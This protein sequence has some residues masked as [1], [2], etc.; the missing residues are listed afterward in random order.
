[1][2]TGYWLGVDLGGTKILAGLF[3]DDL[4]LLARSKQPTAA[5]TGPAGVFGNIV[6][7]VDAV[8]RE[9]NV[10]PAQIRGMGIG[11]PGQIEL[12]TTRVKFAPNLEWRDVDVRP[13]MPA[14]WRWPLVVENDVRMGTYGEFAYGAAKGARNVLGVFVGTGVGGGLILNGELF[15]GFNGN[16]GEIGH[17]VVHWRRGTH[18]EGIA[19]R[20]YMMKRAKDKLDD[21]PKR[22][23]K[24]WKGVDLSA[25]RSSQLAEYYQK[26]DPIAV[27]LVDDAA[28]ALGGA[29]GGLINFVSPEVIVLGGGVTGAL[30]DN[31][32]ERIW[33]IAQRYT[34]PGAAA[35][36]RCV[37]AQLG[38]DSG[39]VGCAAYAKSRTPVVAPTEVV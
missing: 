8:V 14:S 38:D 36:V 20:K 24:E 29:L 13:L 11:V 31:F 25:V 16:A 12:G 18:L 7:A 21:S 33:E 6:K 32:I 34:L 17:L 26:D 3:D 5:D 2:S 27:E 28:R 23:R 9:S 37:A 39:I 1:M 19:G 15:T 4:R 30:G 35:G 10:D 22:V